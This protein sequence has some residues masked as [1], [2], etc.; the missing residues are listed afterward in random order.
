MNIIAFDPGQKGGIAFSSDG[1]IGARS[2]PLAGKV[3][4]LATIAAIIKNAQPELAII[5]KVGSMPGQGVASTF[6]FGTG[7]G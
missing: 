5:E 1:R 7:Y 6:T 4:D 2:M 3:L